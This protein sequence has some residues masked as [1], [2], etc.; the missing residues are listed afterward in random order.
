MG[1]RITYITVRR[2]KNYKSFGVVKTTT[3]SYFRALHHVS[4]QEA[5]GILDPFQRWADR[6]CVVCGQASDDIR[7]PNDVCGRNLCQET[8]HGRVGV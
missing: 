8:I 5:I 3:D 6:Q 1:S 4:H 2:F 7:E